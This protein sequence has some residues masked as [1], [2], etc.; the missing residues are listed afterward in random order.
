MLLVPGSFASLQ[1]SLTVNCA[2]YAGG[3]CVCSTGRVPGSVT[4]EPLMQGAG[5]RLSTRC[6][7]P[8]KRIKMS[9]RHKRVVLSFAHDK[10]LFALR[11]S[12][13]SHQS[14][15]LGESGRK[16]IH[17][18]LD[19]PS[20][21]PQV[22]WNQVARHE[23]EVVHVLSSGRQP[24]QADSAGWQARGRMVINGRRP[25]CSGSNVQAG[26]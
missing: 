9:G 26:T 7:P 14:F 24:A 21:P 8:R 16:R 18:P 25:P 23:L 15:A 19:R 2:Q 4:G 20:G 5:P 6:F 13:T 10:Y 1:Q 12:R 22:G 3:G 17:A 11:L